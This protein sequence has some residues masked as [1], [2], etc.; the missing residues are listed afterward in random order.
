MSKFLNFRLFCLIIVL[1]LNSKF[2]FANKCEFK[3]TKYW[4]AQYYGCNILPNS[5]KAEKHFTGKND[6]DVNAVI[7]D[8]NKLRIQQFTQSE[9]SFFQRFK[10]LNGISIKNVKS[11]AGDSIQNFGNLKVFELSSTEVRELPVNFFSGNSKLF[12]II[13]FETKLTSLPENIFSNQKDLKWLRLEKS[14]INSLPANIFKPL[15]N[16]KILSIAQ[17]KIRTLNPA[18]F[19]TLGR[20][21][22]I[23]LGENQIS[24]LP[25]NIFNKL[26]NLD[27]ISIDKNKLTTIHSD[28]FG[29]INKLTFVDFNS[30]KI[31]AIDEKFIDKFE[32]DWMNFENNVCTNDYIFNKEAVKQKLKACIDN[33]QPR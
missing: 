2:I 17:N 29:D 24:D 28:S 8:G 18:W 9:T 20:L 21:E 6:D 16:L 22:K 3:N 32:M 11:I 15:T 23:A 7:F 12:E 27:F 31:N 13:L 4:V 33:Y 26:V 25:K 30:N 14:Q 19:E 10:N 1:S 5:N